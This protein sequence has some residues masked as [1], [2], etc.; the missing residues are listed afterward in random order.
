MRALHWRWVLGALMVAAVAFAVRPLAPG[1]GPENWFP[2]ADKLHHLWFFALLWWLGRRAGI[3][4]TPGWALALLA[5]GVAIEGAQAL[6][7]TREV[8]LLDVA[9]DGAG[10]AV[11]WLASLGRASRQPEEHRG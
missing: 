6:T 5:F 3:A 8:S 11:G 1:Q 2:Y 9:A 7:P 10:I 4:A